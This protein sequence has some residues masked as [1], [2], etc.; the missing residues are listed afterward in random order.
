M[1]RRRR[2]RPQRIDRA[3]PTAR[4][5]EQLIRLPAIRVIGPNGEHFGTITPQEG[6]ERAREAGLDL[7]EVNPK[8]LPPVCRIVDFSKFKYQLEKERRTKKGR[9]VEVKGVRISIRISENDLL[10]KARQADKFLGQGHKVRIEL[11]LR[12]RERENRAYG[13]SM[14]NRFIEKM[15]TPT[16]VESTPKPQRLGFAMVVARTDAPP[17]TEEELS[18]M[19]D[20][21]TEEAEA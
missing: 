2:R 8:A 12:G 14:F 20:A 10:F 16:R 1:R 9:K 21:A 11:I 6:M 18:D 13:M 15:E 3:K 4:A 17:P 19:D 5:N 7:V